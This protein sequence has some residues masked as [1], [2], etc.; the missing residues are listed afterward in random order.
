[1]A[2][3]GIRSRSNASPSALP[4]E[5]ITNTPSSKALAGSLSASKIPRPSPLGQAARASSASASPSASAAQIAQ[6]AAGSV[7]LIPKLG[8]LSLA[9]GPDPSNRNAGGDDHVPQEVQ[10]KKKDSQYLQVHPSLYLCDHLSCL[11]VCL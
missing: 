9:A 4:F 5:D 1:M 10:E 6:A 3:L 7:T 8:D 2:S 11:A